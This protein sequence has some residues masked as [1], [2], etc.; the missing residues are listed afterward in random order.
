MRHKNGKS[1]LTTWSMG[2]LCVLALAGVAVAAQ[3][4][5][6]IFTSLGNGTTVNG[7][8][9]QAKADV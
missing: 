1:K 2:L 3:F 9:Y 6:A 4:F 8:I 7:N 5:G